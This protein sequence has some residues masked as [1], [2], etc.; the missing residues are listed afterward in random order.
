MGG[1]E[2]WLRGPEA[3]LRGKYVQTCGRTYGRKISPFNRFLSPIGAAAQKAE[4]ATMIFATI[5]TTAKN[6][7][8]WPI[9][10]FW[11]AAPIGDKDL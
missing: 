3:W 6:G 10:A 2:A 8:F 1:L 5:S 9:L 7:R 4:T 11:A